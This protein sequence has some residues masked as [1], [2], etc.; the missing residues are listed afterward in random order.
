MRRALALSREVANAPSVAWGRVVLPDIPFRPV[1]QAA[2]T[3][4][5][6][7]AVPCAASPGRLGA[8]SSDM[9]TGP[10]PLGAQRLPAA[11]YRRP[12][13]VVARDLLGRI[14]CRRL[15]D[16]TVLRGRVVEV[17]AYDGPADRASHAFRGLTPRNRSMFEAGGLAY[18]Y[19]IYGLHHCL[20]V[21]TGEAGHPSAVLL[22][23][24]T[25][26]GA[27]PA[28]GPGRLAQAFRVDRSLDGASFLSGPLWLEA[29][30]PVA[31]PAVRRTRRI[32]VESAGP[33][34]AA[35]RL[36]FVIAGH[37]DVSGP[38]ALR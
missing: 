1:D 7:R 22:R 6:R 26:P 9:G 21:V 25:P 28:S 12:G 30:A 36:R 11:F 13:P 24:T 17:E 19:L 14:L 18:V 33:W 2:G 20:N 32:G 34:W 27:V 10:S 35:R 15:P 16:G 5:E 4:P 8:V 29:G 23:A 38:R 37:P 31:D 3:G